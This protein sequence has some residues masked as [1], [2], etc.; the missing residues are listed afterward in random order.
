MKKICVVTGTKDIIHN[1]LKEINSFFLKSNEEIEKVNLLILSWEA[2]EIN[3]FKIPYWVDHV[4]YICNEELIIVE[5]VLEVLEKIFYENLFQLII[6]PSDYFSNNICVR[7]A[8]R[9]DYDNIN[10]IKTLKYSKENFVVTK[11]IYSSN[12]IGEFKF[13]KTKICVSVENLP[14]V[15]YLES[16]K[17]T[18]ENL[19]LEIE[20]EDW[21]EEI[22][23]T[24]KDVKESFADSEFVVIVGKGIGSKENAEIIKKIFDNFKCKVGGTR[25]VVMNGWLPIE[26][27]I[28]VSGSM[29]AP[30]LCLT[31]GVSGQ[32]ALM[33]G[34]VQSKKIIAIDVDKD[35][36]I[37]KQSDYIFN[38]DYK[39]FI[40]KVQELIPRR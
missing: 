14:K 18:W 31:I 35:S 8:K 38:I 30:E 6:F 5:K 27:L 11:N 15:D 13:F 25:P 4:S 40:E 2:V 17:Y 33:S 22:L 12:L 10:F 3:D 32:R 16:K 9:L 29:I 28:G 24:S 21:V 23:V 26:D 37:N 7:I 1:Q 20:L 36:E 34:I 39:E 19:V